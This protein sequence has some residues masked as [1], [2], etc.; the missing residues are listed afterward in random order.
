MRIIILLSIFSTFTLIQSKVFCQNKNI[1][2]IGLTLENITQPS[3]YIYTSVLKTT[4][5]SICLVPGISYE[6]KLSRKSGLELELRYRQAIT[7]YFTF[8][9]PENQTYPSYLFPQNYSTKEVFLSLPITYKFNSRIVNF[10]LGPSLEYLLASKQLN[11]N[12]YSHI[13]GKE[14]Y[15]NKLSV[16]IITKVSKVIKIYKA[17]VIEPAF[18]YNPI[19]TYSKNYL[20][21]LFAAKYKF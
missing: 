14:Y 4:P 1:I 18:F 8:P 17:I 9:P 5:S 21:I 13:P 2:G 11:V 10:S 19:L 20:G 6:R 15:S 7:S 3:K 12:S 16:G